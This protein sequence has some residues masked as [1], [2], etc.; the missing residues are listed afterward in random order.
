MAAVIRAILLDGEARNPAI[1]EANAA[2]GK[3]R[4]PL[5]RIAA[6]ARTFLSSS[7]SGTY[8]QTGNQVMTITTATAS[9]HSA[10]DSVWL[11]FSSN[12]TGSPPVAPTNNP[13]TGAYTVLGSPAPTANSFAV[14]ASGIA[15]PA[16]TE[17]QGSSTLTVNT[18]GP[19]VGDEVYLDFPTGGIPSGVYSVTALPDSSH[20]TVSPPP[21]LRRRYRGPLS[22]RSCRPMCPSPTRPGPLPACL[23]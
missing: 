8:S 15:I 1:A 5:L 14:N 4:E 13:S 22:C 11:D 12:D 7:N 10:G 18:G 9:L 17:A 19:S 21:P 2:A 6:P 23:R 3:Q 20:F 16:Y